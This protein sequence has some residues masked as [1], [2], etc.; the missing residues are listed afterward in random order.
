MSR[1][2]TTTSRNRSNA[3]RS[4]HTVGSALHGQKLVGS[5]VAGM[6]TS[7]K[8]VRGNGRGSELGSLGSERGEGLEKATLRLDRQG[9]LPDM[10]LNHDKQ[11]QSLLCYRYTIGQSVRRQPLGIP[12]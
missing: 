10:D 11:I 6:A 12:G 1:I 7:L 9:W 4:M 5:R 3:L 2:P 8:G